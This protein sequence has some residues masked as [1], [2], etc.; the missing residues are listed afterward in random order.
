MARCLQV[1]DG[2][3]DTLAAHFRRPQNLLDALQY[4]HRRPRRRSRNRHHQIFDEA[5]RHLIQRQRHEL[6]QMLR[7]TLASFVCRITYGES[8]ATEPAVGA[9]VYCDTTVV[10]LQSSE[11]S[12]R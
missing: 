11:A 1:K 3:L 12:E 2:L 6:F 8:I 10:D 7:R 4:D 9:V 5:R